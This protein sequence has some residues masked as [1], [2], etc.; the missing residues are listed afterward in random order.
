MVERARRFLAAEEGAELLGFNGAH[1]QAGYGRLPG[2]AVE[3]AVLVEINEQHACTFEREGRGDGG[4]GRALSDPTLGRRK[5]NNHANLK[6]GFG[7]N[8]DLGN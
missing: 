6:Y 5:R 2:P 4:A 8:V 3:G 7:A 1:R